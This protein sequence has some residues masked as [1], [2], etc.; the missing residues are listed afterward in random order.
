MAT[1]STEQ[2]IEAVSF[3]GDAL[4]FGNRVNYFQGNVVTVDAVTSTLLNVP[5]LGANSNIIEVLVT[6]V[7]TE[8]GDVVGYRLRALVKNF[9][10]P[11]IIEGS[12]DKWERETVNASGCDANLV[13]DGGDIDLDVTGYNDGSAQRVKWRGSIWVVSGSGS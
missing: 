13:V 3:T 5:F 2:E 12:V 11:A 6:G 4:P 8:N 10:G 9:G 1:R 7:N